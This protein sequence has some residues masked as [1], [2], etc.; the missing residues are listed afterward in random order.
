MAPSPAGVRGS[1]W[2]PVEQ[3][4]AA[5]GRLR[6]GSKTGGNRDFR[7]PPKYAH[8]RHRGEYRRQQEQEKE[9]LPW[10]RLRASLRRNGPSLE[11]CKK[12]NGQFKVGDHFSRR[13][14]APAEYPD[15]NTEGRQLAMTA[16]RA[17]HE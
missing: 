1:A 13:P 6:C 16:L 2:Q 12:G 10:L 7:S 8:H 17:N 5:P 4:S 3:T 15:Q 9:S 11:R 14:I